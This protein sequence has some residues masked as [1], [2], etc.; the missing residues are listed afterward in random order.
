MVILSTLDVDELL[1]IHGIP[2]L[3]KI[4]VFGYFQLFRG[5]LCV[6]SVIMFA[7]MLYERSLATIMYKTYET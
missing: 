4:G 2:I 5:A 1:L 6:S 7:F 3:T